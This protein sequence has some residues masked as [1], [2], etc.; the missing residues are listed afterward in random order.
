MLVQVR[1]LDSGSLTKGAKTIHPNE[2]IPLS[3]EEQSY[4]KGVTFFFGEGNIQKIDKTTGEV[5]YKTELT[6]PGLWNI[7]HKFA[8]PVTAFSDMDLRGKVYNITKGA[9]VQSRISL[10]GST[11]QTP[12]QKEGRRPFSWFAWKPKS[13]SLKEHKDVTLEGFVFAMRRADEEILNLVINSTENEDKIVECL[14]K[15]FK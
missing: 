1:L 2:S 8:H 5:V 12:P 7:G 10:E 11:I 6:K 3:E 9:V 4:F 13:T 14:Q 15:V